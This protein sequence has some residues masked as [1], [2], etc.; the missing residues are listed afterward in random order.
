MG[1]QKFIVKLHNEQLG[2][3][4]KESAMNLYSDLLPDYKQ[5]QIISLKYYD[6][7]K[8]IRLWGGD[9]F[10]TS[11]YVN[12]NGSNYSSYY[13]TKTGYDKDYNYQINLYYYKGGNLAGNPNNYNSK[14][15]FIRGVIVP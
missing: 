6:I 5:A 9:T 1:E 2:Q 3:I 8:A 11:Q 14:C 12:I 7:N 15:G 13:M 4:T 10:A